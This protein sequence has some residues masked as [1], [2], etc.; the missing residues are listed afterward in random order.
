MV[1]GGYLFDYTIEVL[2]VHKLDVFI[3]VII[4]LTNHRQ[5]HYTISRF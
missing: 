5:T 1:V 2:V 4:R 3:L